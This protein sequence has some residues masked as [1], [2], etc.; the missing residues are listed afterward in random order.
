MPSL[1]RAT[2][3]NEYTSPK[4]VLGFYAGLLAILEVGVVAV[5]AVLASQ[6]D[7]H[8]LVPWVAGF[9]GSVFIAIIGIVVAMNIVDP[10]KLQLGQVTGREFIDYQRRGDSIGGEYIEKPA[11]KS[12]APIQLPAPAPPPEG[13]EV[14]D[15]TDTLPPLPEP[16][17]EN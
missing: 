6:D 12:Q 17:G 7:L 8:Y 11:D 10:T 5:L 13:E 9:G 1:F 2:R 16:P 14:K 4:T 15:D 3:G